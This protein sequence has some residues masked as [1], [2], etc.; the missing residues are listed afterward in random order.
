ML[1]QVQN[2]DKEY[3]NGDA[4]VRALRGVTFSIQPKDFVAVCGPSGSGKTTLLTIIAGLNHPT[5]GEVVIDDI[6]IYKE[7]NSNGLAN[8]RN[9]YIGF[10]FQAFH[11]IPYLTAMENVILPLAH[12]NIR[13]KEKRSM[14]ASALEKVGLSDKSKSLPGKLSGG[15][16]QRVAIA[17]AVVND[18]R[19]L[20]AD[21][22]T[23]N[24]D[25]KTRD[26]ILSLFESIRNDGHTIIMVTHDPVNLQYA[27]KSINIVDGK[28]V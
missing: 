17:R 23:G 6:S 18:P 4:L 3:G 27:S 28:L 21:E 5:E 24:L 13:N 11:L 10:V 12:Q 15:Q 20:L 16:R 8:Y 1:M 26:K 9:E 25:T 19:I 22:P 2:I 14:A 7:L